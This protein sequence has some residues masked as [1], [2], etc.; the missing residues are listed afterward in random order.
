MRLP[1]LPARPKCQLVFK[2]PSPGRRRFRAKLFF[3]AQ[4]VKFKTKDRF[5]VVASPMFYISTSAAKHFFAG[6]LYPTL[7]FDWPAPDAQQRE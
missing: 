4:T 2:S 6:E 1:F 7:Y 5:W 3:E